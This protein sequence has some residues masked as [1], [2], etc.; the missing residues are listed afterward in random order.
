MKQVISDLFRCY[1][2]DS[3]LE[4]IEIVV[5]ETM[6]VYF[7]LSRSAANVEI[8][9]EKTRTRGSSTHSADSNRRIEMRQMN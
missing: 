5:L 8:K 1:S 9:L 7:P 6:K 2:A 4:R 3:E